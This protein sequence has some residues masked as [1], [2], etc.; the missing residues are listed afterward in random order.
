L[1]VVVHLCSKFEV[2]TISDVIKKEVSYALQDCIYLIKITEKK[3]CVDFE[4]CALILKNQCCELLLHFKN[5]FSAKLNFQHH[6]TS[7]QCHMTWSF[8]NIMLI[9][10]FG[11]Q[12]T[13]LL[14]INVK[15]SFSA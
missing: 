2:G 10:R 8:R 7:L 6:Y 13:F 4:K 1:Y 3:Q 15:T 11:A 14:I 5:R 12:V 9:C